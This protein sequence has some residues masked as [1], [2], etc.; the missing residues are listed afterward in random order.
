MTGL[1]RYL[2]SSALLAGFAVYLFWLLR[3]TTD[4]RYSNTQPSD[5]HRTYCSQTDDKLQKSTQGSLAEDMSLTKASVFAVGGVTCLVAGA[6][7]FVWSGAEL[8]R[9]YGWSEDV[10]GL[11]IVAVGTSLPEIISL[12]A[13]LQH[14]RHD[15]ALGSVVGSNLFNL[16]GSWDSRFE[17]FPA[18]L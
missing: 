16:P 5:Q 12:L 7:A 4:P 6:D 10:I 14:R 2:Y 9:S 13:S 11:T 18:S 1:S 8:A 3:H 15:I 17:R